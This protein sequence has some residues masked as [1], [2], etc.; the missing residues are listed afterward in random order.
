VRQLTSLLGQRD[1]AQPLLTLLDGPARVELSG[2]TAAN[3]AAKTANLLTDA[4]G[5]PERIGLLLPL[6]WQAVTLLLGAA[7]T[8]ATVVVARDPADLD[9]CGVVFTT[10]QDA[11]A[12]LD[13]GADDVLAVSTALLGGRV[14]GPL[15]TMVLD[16]GRELPVHGDH[17]L[18]RAPGPIVFAGEEVRPPDLGLTPDDRVLTVL[19]PALGLA[20]GLLAPLRAGSGLVLCPGPLPDPAALDAEGVTAVVGADVAGRRRLDQA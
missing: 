13:A 17:F 4:L 10:A 11:E 7:A 5:A 3:W 14:L 8:G 16:A 20:V 2:A 18:L 1:P 19:P 9:G 6:H 15:P 12:A